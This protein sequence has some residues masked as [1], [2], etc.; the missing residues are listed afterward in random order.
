MLASTSGG[1][2]GLVFGTEGPVHLGGFSLQLAAWAFLLGY[3]LETALRALDGVIERV[4]GSLR[5]TTER[6]NRP[7]PGAQAR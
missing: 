7:A 6:T 2:L 1:L 3:G 4:V 5:D